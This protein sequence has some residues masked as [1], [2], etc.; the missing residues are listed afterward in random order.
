MNDT[1]CKAC[2]AQ[3][4]E[5]WETE[6]SRSTHL[7]VATYQYDVPLYAQSEEDESVFCDECAEG[8]AQLR[9]T[10]AQLN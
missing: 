2:G 5:P 9:A 1:C 3:A 7:V 10:W 8:F 6:R 4:G